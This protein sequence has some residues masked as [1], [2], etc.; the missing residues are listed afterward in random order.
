MRIYPWGSAAPSCGKNAVYSTPS[1]GCGAGTTQPVGQGSLEGLSPYGLRDLAG[2]VAEWV[3]DWYEATW[4]GQSP[5]DDP[6]GPAST[7]T[8]Q[9][10]YRGG[11]FGETSE[12]LRAGARKG[13]AEDTATDS[14]GLRC[15]RPVPAGATC[16]D[17]NPCTEDS[18]SPDGKCAFA[19]APK[20]GQPCGQG[21]KCQGGKCEGGLVCDDGNPCTKDGQDAQGMC[22]SDFAAMEGQPCGL[23]GKCQ[24]GKCITPP[25]CGNGK[26]DPGEQCDDGN[27]KKGDGCGDTCQWEPG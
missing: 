17:G 4:Y 22:F 15:V 27:T 13:T 16:D 25:A 1:T 14:L 23:G 8:K 2:N 21:G 12:A 7:A 9:R 18:A 26:L 3:G 19:P 5:K 20:D 11:S 6:T 24:A 10:V